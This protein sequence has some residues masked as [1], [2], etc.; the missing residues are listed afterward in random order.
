[1]CC[2]CEV[3]SLRLIDS[4]FTS[5]RVQFPVLEPLVLMCMQRH[6]CATQEC[7][8]IGAQSWIPK[9]LTLINSHQY[10]LKSGSLPFTPCD[11][12]LYQRAEYIIRGTCPSV[13]NLRTTHWDWLCPQGR[14]RLLVKLN[15][16]WDKLTVSSS[17][18]T[19]LVDASQ[20]SHEKCE[21]HPLTR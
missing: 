6:F 20:H 15:P 13:A 12:G 5:R 11:P 4:N 16:D 7:H 17:S 2:V 8:A 1:M 19:I 9:K 3:S 14:L 21:T 18:S 10:P